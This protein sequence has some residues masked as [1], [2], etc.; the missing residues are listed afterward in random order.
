MPQKRRGRIHR[1]TILRA[2]TGVILA[3]SILPRRI[4]A[5]GAENPRGFVI[6]EP[7]AAK[8][9]ATVLSDGGNAID[10]R[11]ACPRRLRS[12]GRDPKE[13]YRH[14]SGEVITA[15]RVFRAPPGPS[16]S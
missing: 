3:G 5:E 9:G 6:G 12:T 7:T 11:A 15:F 1:R 10:A 8:V 4:F 16:P 14:V 13:P 2:A